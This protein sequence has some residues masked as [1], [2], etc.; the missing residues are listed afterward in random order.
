MTQYR[1]LTFA[2]T[3]RLAA[4]AERKAQEAVA[5]VCLSSQ[6]EQIELMNLQA[7]LDAGEITQAE[8]DTLNPLTRGVDNTKPR[9]YTYD[10]APPIDEETIANELT[11][12]EKR[13]LTLK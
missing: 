10:Q 6:E 13:M 1:E 7:R 5:R 8:F 11:P 12:E 9:Q 2:D 4:E 3:V